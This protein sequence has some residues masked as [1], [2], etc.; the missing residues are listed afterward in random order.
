MH[1]ID[2]LCHSFCA[3]LIY[4]AICIVSITTAGTGSGSLADVLSKSPIRDHIFK[5]IKSDA[6]IPVPGVGSGWLAFLGTRGFCRPLSFL[7]RTFK[8]VATVQS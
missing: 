3:I 6:S 1:V 8:Y 5:L 2:I 7:Q 4:F